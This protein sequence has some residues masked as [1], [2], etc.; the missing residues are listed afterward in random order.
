MMSRKYDYDAVLIGA[1]ISGLVCGCYLAKAGLK[2]LIVEKNS[3]PGG[4]CTSFTR[5]GFKFDA[6]AHS[7]GSL[8]KGGNISNILKDLDLDKKFKFTRNDPQDI[9]ITPS[10]K[11]SIWNDLNK[12]IKEFQ[13]RFPKESANIENFI[14]FL[15]KC[16]GVEFN[17][18]KSITFEFLLNRYFKNEELKS[19]LAFLIFGN[20]GLP[21]SKVSALTAVTLYKEFILDGGYYP[22]GGMQVLSDLLGKRFE[23]LG[24]NLSLSSLATGIKVVNNKVD[25]IM[26]WE[27]D[28][29]SAKYVIAACDASEVFLRLIEEKMT[30]KPFIDRVNKLSA[31]LSAFVLYLGVD[32]NLRTLLK[33]SSN[34]WYLPNY[35]IERLYR[36]TNDGDLMK[37]NWFLMRSSLPDKS[38][39]MLINSPFKDIGYWEENK[40]RLIDEFIKKMEKVVPD[41][42]H[43]I[44]LKDAA[45]PNTL[46]KWTLNHKGAAYGWESSPSQFAIQYLSQTTFI[47]NLYLTGHWATLAQ[48]IPGVAYLGNSTAKIILRKENSK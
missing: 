27:S 1:G 10:Y 45:T 35:D 38:I 24:G 29:I 20:L 11:I 36:L 31:S 19:I 14:G 30:G 41:L 32:K 15:N 12:T 5:N 6:C 34:I 46:Y 18:L 48:G 3:R 7:L 39:T 22:D 8:R 40:K 33:D 43:H 13:N 16:T 25:G 4:Y 28:F 17:S 47:K 42:S 9:I 2:T 44:V 26:I 23:E 21:P 37:L